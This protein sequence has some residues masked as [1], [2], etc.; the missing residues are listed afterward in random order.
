MSAYLQVYM[1]KMAKF[2]WSVKLDDKTVGLWNRWKR[3]RLLKNLNLFFFF[4]IA[5]GLGTAEK[6]FVE[7]HKGKCCMNVP[8]LN[9]IYTSNI[10]LSYLK[11][12]IRNGV[13]K[14]V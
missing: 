1:I 14:K 5:L 2:L 3:E 6:Q 11:L 4:C 12:M 8:K 10:N 9:K 7:K 13:E